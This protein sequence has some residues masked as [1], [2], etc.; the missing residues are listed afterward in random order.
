MSNEWSG[1]ADAYATSFGRLCAGTV[2][3][4][5]ERLP[6]DPGD[7]LDAGAGTGTFAAALA[8]NGWKVQGVDAEPDMVRYATAAHPGVSFGVASLP[9]LPFT[10]GRFDLTVANFVVNHVSSPRDAVAE[11]ARVTAPRGR[12]I[13]TIWPST[14]PSPMNALW[15]EV[16][17]RA[18][19]TP[20]SDHRLTA[21]EDFARST[22]G[23]VGLLH[24][25]GLV[26]ATADEVSWDFVIS[27]DD[28]WQGVEAG[29]ATI[30]ATYRAQNAIHRRAMRRAYEEL[31]GGGI[32]T[33]P[34]TA[35]IASATRT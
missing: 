23:L 27:A 9:A 35:V 1:T 7:A 11:L 13:V 18:G 17:A 12:V 33:L 21:D 28:L 30:G 31:C 25:G 16:I 2:P 6:A 32:L 10:S 4:V 29:I 8:S 24:E 5:L 14:P 34:S 19:A 26:D 22:A 3:H 15:N 20:V